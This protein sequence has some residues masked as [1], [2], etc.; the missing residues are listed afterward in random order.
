ML[1][2]IRAIVLIDGNP[3]L[4]DWVAVVPPAEFL[5]YDQ[6]Q[7]VAALEDRYISRKRVSGVVTPFA[8]I[9]HIQMIHPDDLAVEA[10]RLFQ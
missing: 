10:V 4:E 7:S 1:M 9:G 8:E 2:R 5:L 3:V 6:L